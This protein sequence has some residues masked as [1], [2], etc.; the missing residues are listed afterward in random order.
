MGPREV[1]VAILKTRE[2]TAIPT[3]VK[4]LVGAELYNLNIGLIAEKL[5]ALGL[6]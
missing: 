4:G 5:D 6:T 2:T 3:A 1:P